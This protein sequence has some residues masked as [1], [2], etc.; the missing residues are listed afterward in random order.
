VLAQCVPQYLRPEP[1][2]GT[3]A[4]GGSWNPWPSRE[5][6]RDQEAVGSLEG[7]FREIRYAVALVEPR[8]THAFA[9]IDRPDRSVHLY[10]MSVVLGG[11]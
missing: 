9:F 2:I 10:P 5:R 3:Q 8:G 4:L 11:I 6:L 1:S 7:P